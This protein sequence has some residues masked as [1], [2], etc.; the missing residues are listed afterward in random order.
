M[1][2][3]RCTA[4]AAS[5]TPP[6]FSRS[7][8]LQGS[9]TAKI[10]GDKNIDRRWQRKLDRPEWENLFRL[11]TVVEDFIFYRPVPEDAPEEPVGAAP[12][13]LYLLPGL[14]PTAPMPQAPTGADA[15]EKLA[16][17]LHLTTSEAGEVKA[18]T[19][20][21]RS[22]RLSSSRSWV[23]RVTRPRTC[24]CTPTG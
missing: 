2:W 1:G 7:F 15:K 10:E 19:S 21:W 23:R 16:P 6:V 12:M 20:R 14:A 17:G 18:E 11:A 4:R 8:L 5:T 22:S 24:S 13:V 9:L 3:R